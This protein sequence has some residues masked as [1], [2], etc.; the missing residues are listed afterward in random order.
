LNNEV[1]QT[2]SKQAKNFI[3]DRGLI[4]ESPLTSK[5]KMYA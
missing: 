3:T 5:D 1:S 2:S 4:S